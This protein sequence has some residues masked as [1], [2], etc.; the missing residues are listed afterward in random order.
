MF[1]AMTA[2]YDRLEAIAILSLRWS[3]F[4]VGSAVFCVL[5]AEY[6]SRDAFQLARGIPIALLIAAVGIGAG[7]A[8][9]VAGRLRVVGLM[10][11]L[12]GGIVLESN[13]AAGVVICTAAQACYASSLW[14]VFTRP[15]RLAPWL[16]GALCINA[17][18]M[19]FVIPGIDPG[20]RPVIL[21]YALV[22]TIVLA[23]TLSAWQADPRSPATLRMLIGVLLFVL[24]DCLLAIDRWYMQLASPQLWVQTT[25]F[26]A[27][28]LI[29]SSIPLLVGRGHSHVPP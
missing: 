9:S 13:F 16:A 29:A 3:I 1:V 23:A 14:P 22:E 12:A 11:L 18:I 26:A 4:Y 27:Q 19:A 6:G 10:L 7:L 24:S 17:A 2:C 5:L 20:L 15:L 21:L 25:Y 28:F 8:S